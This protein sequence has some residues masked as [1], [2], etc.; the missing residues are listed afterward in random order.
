MKYSLK[1]K[2]I[3]EFNECGFSDF[4]KYT[5]QLINCA[6]QNAQGTRPVVVGQMSELFP[7]FMA[8]GEEIT[9]DNWHK[10]YVKKYPDAV[11]NAT[12]KIYAQVQ[13]LRNAIS[14]IDR[15]MVEHWVEDLVIAKTFNGLYVQKAILA[16]L[17]KRQGTTYRLAAP[18]EESAGIDGYVGSVPYSVKPDTYK[19]MKRLP[20][21]IAVKMVYYS[22][23]K[24]GLIIEVEDK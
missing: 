2:Q 9:M 17:A 13:N 20:E 18:E 7:E 21:T 11:E 4:P 10:W 3:G 22:K 1:N 16:S 15:K 24:T 23:T 19:T 14:L 12:D 5:S 6:N 8:S